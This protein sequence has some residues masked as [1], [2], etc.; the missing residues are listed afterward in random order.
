MNIPLNTLVAVSNNST[1][2]QIVT[3][4]LNNKLDDAEK[5]SF[6]RWLKLISEKHSLDISAERRKK[7][8]NNLF[9]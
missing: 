2:T 3:D 9:R 6:L 7:N 1:I 4:T 8:R 5:Q